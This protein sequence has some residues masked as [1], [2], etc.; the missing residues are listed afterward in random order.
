[1]TAPC[2]IE[3]I[4]TIDSCTPDHDNHTLTVKSHSEITNF[5]RVCK[6]RLGSSIESNVETAS[7]DNRT[8][9]TEKVNSAENS[10]GKYV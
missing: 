9:S 4:H 2:V 10:V 7:G 8:S 5:N 6:F 3:A 1:M